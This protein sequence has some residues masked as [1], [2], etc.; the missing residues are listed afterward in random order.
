MTT[1]IGF[2]G[3][4]WIGRHY[5]DEFESRMY[6]VVRY[7]LEEQYIGNKDRIST[8]TVVF[9]A[10]PTPT[11]LDGSSQHSFLAQQKSYRRPSLTSLCSIALNFW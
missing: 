10:V 6:D 2:I 3:Q 7:S 1:Q 8:C 9:I 4:G 5:A 11:T